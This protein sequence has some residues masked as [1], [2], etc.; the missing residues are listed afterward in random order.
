MTI[1]C[2]LD[3]SRHSRWALELLRRLRLAPRAR[4]MLLH[5]VDADKFKP[6]RNLDPAARAALK[7]ALGLAELGGREMLAQARALVAGTWSD[8]KTTLV[9]GHPAETIRRA[10]ARNRADLIVMGSRGLTQFRP[11]LLGSVSRRLVVHTPCPVLIV[12]KRTPAFNRIIV[13][14]D[15]SKESARAVE[16]LLQWPLPKTASCAVLSVVPPLPVQSPSVAEDISAVLS[17][18]REPLEREA[19]RVA[20]QAAEIIRRRSYDAVAK[21][22]HGHPGQEIV[23]LAESVKADLVVIGSRGLEGTER[24]LMGSTSDTVVKYAP[25]SVLVVRHP[26][27]MDNR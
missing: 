12:K 7:Q 21:V 25:C 5:A 24:Y 22:T 20:L 23:H 4:L 15:G 18:V 2:A 6:R 13:A 11:F 8:V 16:F 17:K 14:V 19:Y 9:S 10:A 1:L 3:G 26:T 27:L